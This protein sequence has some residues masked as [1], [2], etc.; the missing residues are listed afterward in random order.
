MRTRTRTQINKNT[1][2]HHLIWGNDQRRFGNVGSTLIVSI[3]FAEPNESLWLVGQVRNDS[4]SLFEWIHEKWYSSTVQRGTS[5]DLFRSVSLSSTSER[6]T[7]SAISIR[8]IRSCAV[9]CCSHLHV[10]NRCLSARFS[11]CTI[12]V[13]RVDSFLFGRNPLGNV[14]WTFQRLESVHLFDFTLDC[15]VVGAAH[16]G[17]MV[18]SLGL[19]IVARLRLLRCQSA[20]LSALVQRTSRSSHGDLLVNLVSHVRIEFRPAEQRGEDEKYETNHVDKRKQRDL[21]FFSR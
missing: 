16:S 14:T 8:I 13:F 6:H 18:D 9:C 15:R 1:L 20:G 19:R 17:P 2:I 21:P 3:E 7:I 11:V 10:F 12:S 4:F 5:V